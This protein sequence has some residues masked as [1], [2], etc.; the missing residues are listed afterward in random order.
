MLTATE[1]PH[2]HAKVSITKLHYAAKTV[3]R[4]VSMILAEQFKDSILGT[5]RSWLSKR[6]SLDA[7]A[8]EI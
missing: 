3:D 4:D 8:P 5:V 2:L 1:A 6:V 7:K